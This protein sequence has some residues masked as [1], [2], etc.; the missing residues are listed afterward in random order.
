VAE[1]VEGNR[2]GRIRIVARSPV[3]SGSA[4]G[5]DGDSET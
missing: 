3:G 4:G 1:R 5:E 2:I